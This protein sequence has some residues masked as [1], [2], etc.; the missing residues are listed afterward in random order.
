[1]RIRKDGRIEPFS[2]TPGVCMLLP[3]SGLEVQIFP[4]KF[5]VGSFEWD[6]PIEGPVEGFTAQ[7]DLERPSVRVWGRA[8]SGY[9]RYRL[10]ASLDGFCMQVERGELPTPHSGSHKLFEPPRLERLSL[11]VH[12]QPDWDL[13]TRRCDIA[14]IFPV[15]LRLGQLTPQGQDGPFPDSLLDSARDES[16]FIDLFRAGFSGL[17]MPRLADESH[18]GLPLAPLGSFEGS[19]LPLLTRGAARIRRLFVDEEE[20]V[21]HLLPHL[22]QRLH[23]GRLL[24]APWQLGRFDMEWSR[25]RLRRLILR[26]EK[27][28]E[29]RL[30]T[31][32][33]KRCRLG[34]RLLLAGD[35]VTV[36]ENETLCFDRF[37]R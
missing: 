19:A 27:A 3:G 7:L 17:M 37:E 24:D 32:G 25:R 4:A 5:R 6:L 20:G 2:H 10:I 1:M 12:K 16:S 35:L 15:W 22:P 28:G 11:G 29:F 14:E 33:W 18:L 30:E 36:G 31:D 34:Q 13:V 21:L 23:C 8:K 26:T 9:F